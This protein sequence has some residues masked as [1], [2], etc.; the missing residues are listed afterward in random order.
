M[1][2]TLS[3]VTYILPCTDLNHISNPLISMILTCYF[4]IACTASLV[5]EPCL[6][7]PSPLLYSVFTKCCL[8]TPSTLFGP[9]HSELSCVW[10]QQQRLRNPRSALAIKSWTILSENDQVYPVF[11]QFPSPLRP[12]SSF[13]SFTCHV[14]QGGA[15]MPAS[16]NRGS[17]LRIVVRRLTG[18]FDWKL[19]PQGVKLLLRT[20]TTASQTSY[21]RGQA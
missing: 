17:H 4:F 14:Q 3:S 16:C 19:A 18:H 21:P 7:P 8:A 15:S 20:M 2:L 6:S 1:S 5:L 9:L 12:R 13:F 10:G 11:P